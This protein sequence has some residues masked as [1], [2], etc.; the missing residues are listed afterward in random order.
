MKRQLRF[1][2]RGRIILSGSREVSRKDDLKP[3]W[4]GWFYEDAMHRRWKQAQ[5]RL[6]ERYRTS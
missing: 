1:N 3:S 2:W 4:A 6:A 5:A